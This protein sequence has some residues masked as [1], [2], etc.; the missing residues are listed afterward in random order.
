MQANC[1]ITEAGQ[2]FSEISIQPEYAVAEYIMR[3]LRKRYQLSISV[4]ETLFL[5]LRLTK[6]VSEEE[7]FRLFGEPLD[8]VYE[9]PLEDMLRAG[10][11][12]RREGWVRLTRR[13]IDVSN[14]VM[15]Q[16]LL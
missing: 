14:Y 4:E 8:K 9:K 13:G 16:F 10:L 15:A 5:G 3:I 11:L 6:G 2:S 12:E 7:F 1:F